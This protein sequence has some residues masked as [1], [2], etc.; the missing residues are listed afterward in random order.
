MR[1]SRLRSRLRAPSITPGE[2]LSV[3]G[4][5]RGI[6]VRPVPDRHVPRSRLR[7]PRDGSSPFASLNLRLGAQ[8]RTPSAAAI[9]YNGSVHG[10]ARVAESERS[11]SYAP[12]IRQRQV[13]R[14][15][16]R[17]HQEPHQPVR[18]QALPR[19]RRQALRRLPREPRAPRV[20]ARQQVPHVE[21][22]GRRGRDHHCDQREP[23]REIKDARRSGHHLRR[24]GPAPA[25]RVPLARVRHLRRR[26]YPLR[27]PAFRR[28][29]PLAPRRPGNQKLPALPHRRVPLRHRAHRLRRG[30]RQKRVRGNDAPARRGD[31][32][33]PRFGQDG[34]LSLAALSRA[35]ARQPG[36]IR[37]IRDVPHLEP[38]AE[39]P[40]Q[41]RLRGRDGR[42]GRRELHRPLP[43]RGLREDHG[44]LQPRR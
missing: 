15:S 44:E 19:V 24:G 4:K 3:P 29:I 1:A 34:H 16:G 20:R 36:G 7:P 5:P 18:G 13:H 39:A 33:R 42:F 9:L 32:T 38:A 21:D 8:A 23:Y 30:L 43:L 10:Y 11:R 27:E 25:R 37:E 14:T 17:A 12:R 41:H 6:N 22:H 26:D 35:Q 40:R 2:S 31:R 28:G